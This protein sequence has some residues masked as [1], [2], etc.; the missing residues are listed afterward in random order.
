MTSNDETAQ[1]EKSLWQA[2]GR[3]IWRFG[4]TV[5]VAIAA[6]A[7]LWVKANVPS[8]EQFE[9]LQSNAASKAQFE[10]LAGQVQGVRDELLR[11]TDHQDRL[12]DFELRL[13]D[14]ERKFPPR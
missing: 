13:R 7:A 3:F 11:R 6:Y 12:R 2:T 10:A 9:A 4:M 1:E 8:R 5:G 14:L